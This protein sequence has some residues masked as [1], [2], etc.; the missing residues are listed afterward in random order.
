MSLL[1]KKKILLKEG[2]FTKISLSILVLFSK[3]RDMVEVF[4]K[5]SMGLFMKEIGRIIN[6]M[7]RE[8]LFTMITVFTPEALRKEREKVMENMLT[9]KLFTME[10]LV[11]TLSMAKAK[12]Y[13]QMVLSMLGVL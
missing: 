1:T 5:L 10:S 8:T 3:G 9:A 2:S 12:K 7:G 11:M 4:S 6:L 13:I